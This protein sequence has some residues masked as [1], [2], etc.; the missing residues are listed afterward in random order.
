MYGDM[1]VNRFVEVGGSLCR[2]IFVDLEMCG[3]REVFI[4]WDMPVK[5]GLSCVDRRS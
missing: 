2:K 4:D 1:C 5:R 3:Y